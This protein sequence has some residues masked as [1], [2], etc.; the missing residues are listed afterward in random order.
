MIKPRLQQYVNQELSDAQAVFRKGRG[1]R[2]Q[3]PNIPWVTEKA[4]ETPMSASLTTLKLL[5]VWTSANP[6]R[7]HFKEE[8][9]IGFP[10][11]S[12]SKSAVEKCP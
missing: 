12:S 4:R 9:R 7:R 2:D 10:A 6:K 3:I 1:N 8:T 5:T 11:D